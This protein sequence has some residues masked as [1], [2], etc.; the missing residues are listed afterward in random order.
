MPDISSQDW[1]LDAA[2]CFML[3]GWM[4]TR[5]CMCG[6]Y[7]MTVCV[8]LFERVAWFQG[9]DQWMT[10]FFTSRLVSIGSVCACFTPSC[11]VLSVSGRFLLFVH[12]V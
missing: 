6:R 11:V 1:I 12:G 2:G 5:R 4:V 8:F 3:C 7:L 9:A 10:V